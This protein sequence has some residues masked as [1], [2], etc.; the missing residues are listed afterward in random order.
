MPATW[1]ATGWLR[2][3]FDHAIAVAGMARSYQEGLDAA[4]LASLKRPGH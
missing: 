4:S 2:G 3:S 1:M